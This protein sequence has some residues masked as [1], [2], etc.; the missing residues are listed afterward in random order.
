MAPLM[1]SAPIRKRTEQH[2]FMRDLWQWLVWF[3]QN[4][5]EE[6]GALTMSPGKRRFEVLCP[7]LTGAGELSCEPNTSKFSRALAA[8][9]DF[10]MHFMG[11]PGTSELSRGTR[12]GARW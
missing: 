5:D 10:D 6:V 3:V 2:P 8:A 1:Q 11:A 9:S 12:Q 7:L 4:S